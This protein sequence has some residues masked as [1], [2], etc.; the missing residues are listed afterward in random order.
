M[1]WKVKNV[2]SKSWSDN[3]ELVFVSGD[4]LHTYGDEY[5]MSKEIEPVGLATLIVDMT[6]PKQEGIYTTYWGLKNKSGKIFCQF[7]LM[8]RVFK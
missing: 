7:S 1:T 5:A 4:K 8:V 3:V 2:G 6:T